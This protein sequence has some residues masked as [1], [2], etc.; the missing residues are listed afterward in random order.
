MRLEGSNLLDHGP[1]NVDAIRAL[2][3]STEDN[4]WQSTAANRKMLAAKRSGSSVILQTWTTEF[5]PVTYSASYRKIDECGELHVFRDQQHQS[6]WRALEETVIPVIR[7][8]YPSGE[9]AMVQFAVL[10]AGAEIGRHVDATIYS[11]MHGLHIPIV[12]NPQVEFTIGDDDARYQLRQD[13]LYELDNT[14]FHSVENGSEQDRIHLMIDVL[15]DTIGKVCVHNTEDA[16]TSATVSRPIKFGVSVLCRAAPENQI[17]GRFFLV[18]P[19]TLQCDFDLVLENSVLPDN[20]RGGG[21]GFRGNV[22]D[23]VSKKIFVADYAGIT[24]LSGQLEKLMRIAHPAMM[25]IHALAV[26]DGH[27]WAVSTANDTIFKFSIEDGKFSGAWEFHSSPNGKPVACCTMDPQR[28]VAEPGNSRFH[29][30]ALSFHKGILMTGGLRSNGIIRLSQAGDVDF[31]PGPAGA[32]DF[33]VLQNKIVLLDTE[34]TSVRVLSLEGSEVMSATLPEH[35]YGG[36]NQQ[37]HP[38]I[39]RPGFLRGISRFA[40]PYV[41]VGF[42]PAGVALFDTRSGQFFECFNCTRDVRWMVAGLSLIE[43]EV[44]A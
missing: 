29:L 10:P 13:R 14:E 22:Q 7:E 19:N 43:T 17:H 26:E 15:P 8:L 23:P 37:C 42:A 3:P 34:A 28:S 32:H 20:P 16:F 41:A 27:V 36:V 18:D 1:I 5:N 6:L 9:I 25:H 40:G 24:V 12:T 21:R 44:E 38:S 33:V 2:L 4:F 11:D 30:N 39:S 35:I 31:I